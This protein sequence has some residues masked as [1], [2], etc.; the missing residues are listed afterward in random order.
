MNFKLY[1]NFGALNSG[2]VFAAIEQGL[3]SLGHKIVDQDE[4]ISVI[5]SV[6]WHGRMASNKLIYESNKQHNKKTL[7]IEVGNFFRGKTWRLSMNHIDA[8][9]IYGFN[10]D[11]DRNRPAK[12]GL[13]LNDLNLK[14]RSEILLA[15]QHE[16][17][18]QWQG[19]PS[20]S[21]WVNQMIADIRRYSDRKIY[22]RPHPRCPLRGNIIGGTLIAPRQIQGTYDDFDFDTN[23][24]CVINHNSGPC[25]QAAIKG[26]P[27][28]CNRTSL[29]YPVSD[30][31]ENIDKINLGDRIEWLIKLSHTE[32]TVSELGTGQPLQRILNEIT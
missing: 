13:R 19:L 4:D 10:K 11:L 25:I 24:H 14:R 29:A 2:P 3:L 6:L 23:Y 12:L 26:T 27:V 18:L 21:E 5:W 31:L 1:K 7:I 8:T 20:T 15:C 30:L 17:S 16:K 9:G 28:I 32:W 22:V